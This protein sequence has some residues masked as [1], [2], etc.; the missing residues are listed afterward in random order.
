MKAGEIVAAAPSCPFCQHLTVVGGTASTNDDLLEELRSGAPN[1]RVLIAD[2]QMGGRGR[3]GHSW[4]SPAGV[5]LYMS[6]LLRPRL[7]DVAALTPLALVAGLA[8]AESIRAST[9]VDAK[10]KWPNDVLIGR[11]KV[12]GILMEAAESRSGGPALVIGIGLNVNQRAFPVDLVDI[13]T[14]LFI[15]TGQTYARSLVAADLLRRLHQRISEALE[16]STESVLDAWS[17]LSSTIGRRVRPQDG[18]E[19]IALSI[20]VS[21]ALVVRDD[22]GEVHRVIA[23][24]IDEI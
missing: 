5:N 24:L 6:V 9:G 1:G 20:D 12:A 3:V 7:D 13:A 21:G 8:V 10:V 23:G 4:H 15:E 22:S 14:S 19:G 16:G 17:A 18:P 11:R 2:Q